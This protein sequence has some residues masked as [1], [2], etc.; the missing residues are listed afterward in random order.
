MPTYFPPWLWLT[1]S[2]LAGWLLGVLSYE[3]WCKAMRARRA[4]LA[5]Q[6]ELAY[7][8]EQERE[9]CAIHD[10][11]LQGMQGILLSFQ[12]VGQRLPSGC[13]ERAAIER[14]LDQGDAALADGRQRLQ[15][16]R[17]PAGRGAGAATPPRS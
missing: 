5:R 14:L 8:A 1:A 2:V 11:L 6:A 9:A 10:A 17:T 16:L 15:A 4:L 7:L 13:A 3:R 12:S